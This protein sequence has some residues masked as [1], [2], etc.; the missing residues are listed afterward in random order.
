V[1]TILITTSPARGHLY[2]MMDVALE[3]Q[4]SGHDVVV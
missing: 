4:R 3:L 1:S 2:P